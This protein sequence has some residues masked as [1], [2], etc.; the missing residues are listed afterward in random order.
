[1]LVMLKAGGMFGSPMWVWVLVWSLIQHGSSANL[2]PE[3]RF[4]PT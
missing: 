4:L 1:M 3:L 2:P